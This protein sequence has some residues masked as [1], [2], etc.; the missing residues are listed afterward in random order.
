MTTG[1]RSLG[2]PERLGEYLRCSADGLSEALSGQRQ[3]ALAGVRKRVGQVLLE[4]G[5]ISQDELIAAIHAQRVDRLR[6]CPAFVGLTP[7]EI[8][9]ISDLFEEYS[10]AAGVQFIEQG[11]MA[12]SIYFVARG[13]AQV[14]RR[15]DEGHEIP[16]VIREPGEA[17]G[18][19]AYFTGGRRSAS[20][21]ALQDMELL[22]ISY[23]DVP[24][25][26]D[27]VP[28]FS[29]HLL[30][31]VSDRLRHVTISFQ[32][33]M[34][35]ART[36]ERSL[37]S[38]YDS[39]DISDVVRLGKGI[40]G[41]IERAVLISSKVMNADRATL[42]L[43]DVA[44]GELWSKVAQGEQTR[45]IRVP[46]GIG[47]VGWV[48]QHDQLLN[49]DDVYTDFRFNP[50]VDRHTGYRTRSMLC[51]PV[52]NL[53]GEIIGVIQIINKKTGRFTQEDELLFP[54]LVYQIAIG[55]DNYQLYQK[56]LTNHQKMAVLLDVATSI[57]QTLDLEALIS[58][59]IAKVTEILHA[60][61]SSLF[62]LDRETGHLWSK[63]AEGTEV[64]EIRF[65]QS[66][67]LAGHAVS[68]GQVLNIKDAYEDPR[69]NPEVDQRTAFRTRSVLCVPVINR[70]GEI[71]GVTQAMN[72][73]GGFFDLED[74]DLLRA[75]SSQIA[76]ALE[77]AQLYER[78][79]TM[80]NYLESVQESISN[81]ILT[82]DSSYR[83]VTA[84]RAAAGLFQQ[85]VEKLLGKDVRDLVGTGN[86]HLISGIDQVYESHRAAV[87]Y[88]VDLTVPN[89]R[90]SSVNLNIVPLV[91][92]KGDHQ[93]LVA[94]LEDISRE[95]RVKGT[96]TRY[97][98]KDIVERVLDDPEKQ[99]LGGVQSQ[100]TILFSDIR[101]FTAIAEGLD[102]KQTMEFLN[103]YF[104][105][106]VDVVFR[107]RG[108]LDKYIGDAI[109]AVFGVPY[110]QPDD[111]MRAVRT[112]LGMR[113]TLA[114]LNARRRPAVQRPIRIGVG[115][116]RRSGRTHRAASIL[117]ESVSCQSL[118][119]R[120]H[121]LS[122]GAGS[123]R[124]S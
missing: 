68:T 20:V 54:A 70:D 93:G 40:E 81:S 61:R 52:K 35:K 51:G 34:Q 5:A 124:S 79:V 119:H 112:A 101:G 33:T 30:H 89:G 82:L 65:P 15:D 117:Q 2:K 77:N 8:S 55:L 73:R 25:A 38:I 102:A 110:V 13:R 60:E 47:I 42:F 71:I 121:A 9:T 62:L 49:I 105:S 28:A 63:V 87:D 53:N 14:L 58:R 17:I 59:I 75:L 109:M 113:T 6:E 106:M 45:E 100:A 66:L 80:K 31:L 3:L 116:C 118:S 7:E 85:G 32:E 83:I 111:A 92:H 23:A 88:D 64:A 24:R 107:E 10:V 74:E 56:I 44:S 37:R 22:R 86:T 67:G 78:T 46:A 90:E 123:A 48:T 19:V 27:L 95:K 96:L 99:A 94:V 114:S 11:T 108:V 84:N 39:L 115:I 41:L 91:G 104:A 1:I 29:R 26:L 69:F 16:L 120:I 57:T 12:D 18:E 98:S 43:I 76:V 122:G 36:A 103:D 21:Q 72:K 4:A 50:E 97:M